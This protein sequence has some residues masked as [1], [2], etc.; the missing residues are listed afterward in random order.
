MQQAGQIA[1]A[2]SLSKQKGVGS[3]HKGGLTL[4]RCWERQCR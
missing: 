4:D 1:G 3:V 2:T